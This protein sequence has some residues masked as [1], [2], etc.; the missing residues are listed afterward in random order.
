[1]TRDRVLHAFLL[2]A[3]TLA[4]AAAATVAG[5]APPPG[6]V[7]IPLEA[8]DRLVD[9]AAH[10]PKSHE[11]PPIPATVARA[12]MQAQVAN[13]VV[14]GTIALAGEVFRTGAVKVPLVSG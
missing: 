13:G 8:Y 12:S 14:S 1:M 5:A 6:T 11:Q 2:I 10:P 7:T 9:R 3:I 4:A